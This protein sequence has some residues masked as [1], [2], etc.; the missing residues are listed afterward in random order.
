MM[1]NVK[2]A[3]RL[4]SITLPVL[5]LPGLLLF[6]DQSPSREQPIIEHLFFVSFLIPIHVD[7]IPL[8]SINSHCCWAQL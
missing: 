4:K 3:Y 7:L 2:G 1:M 6:F 8:P 5:K